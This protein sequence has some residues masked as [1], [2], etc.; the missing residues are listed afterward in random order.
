QE[1]TPEL[2]Q[3]RCTTSELDKLEPFVQTRLVV[4][5]DYSFSYSLSVY[6]LE[7]YI[8]PAPLMV[9]LQLKHLESGELPI[10]RCSR[11]KARDGSVGKVC[12]FLVDPDNEAITHLILKIGHWWN[13]KEIAIPVEQIDRVE[14]TTVY[15]K[16]DK[17]GV[18]MLPPIET[19]NIRIP[20]P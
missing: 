6:G 9:P 5:G 4:V 8:I 17:K 1:G 18:E 13:R 14:E 16:L 3:L 10:Q 2:I 11:V 12:E 19:V 7:P 20:K 15:L